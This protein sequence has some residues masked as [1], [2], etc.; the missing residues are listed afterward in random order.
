M[1][2]DLTV[3]APPDAAPEVIAALH[4]YADLESTAGARIY[5]LDE[6]R[7]ADAVAAGESADDV[8]A[9]LTAH[10]SVPVA[11]NVDYLVRDVARRHGRLRAGTASSYLRSEDAGLLSRA[12]G[13]KAA[14]LR[15]LAPT[16]AVSALARERL[17][18]ALRAG[19][20]AAVGEDVAGATELA[21][22]LAAAPVGARRGCLPALRAAADPVALARRLTTAHSPLPHDDEER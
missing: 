3:I 6:G 18:A 11:Q 7:L 9:W 1:Q 2:A 13:V 10:S 22:T 8:L 14:K 5:R 15:L 21:A 12:V 16:V 19:G 4:R 17:L 20:V